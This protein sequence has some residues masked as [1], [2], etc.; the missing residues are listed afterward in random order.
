MPVLPDLR[1]INSVVTDY[2]N[3][4]FPEKFTQEDITK[5]ILHCEEAFALVIRAGEIVE[6]RGIT[7]QTIFLAFMSDVVA[8]KREALR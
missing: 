7:E 2:V 1:D 8:R 5:I 6:S 4:L 3:A